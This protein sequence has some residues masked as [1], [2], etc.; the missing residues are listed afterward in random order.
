MEK[1]LENNER[2]LNSVIVAE[3]LLHQFI[4][5]PTKSYYAL[6]EEFVSGSKSHLTNKEKKDFCYRTIYCSQVALMREILCLVQNAVKRGRVNLTSDVFSSQIKKVKERTIIKGGKELSNF[7]Y[8][9]A[10]RNAFAHNNELSKDNVIEYFSNGIDKNKLILDCKDAGICVSLT[11]KD[12]QE[13]VEAIFK[14][15]NKTEALGVYPVR[16]ENAIKGGYFSTDNINRYITGYDG[17]NAVDLTLDDHQKQTINNFVSSGTI[18]NEQVLIPYFMDGKECGIRLV[19][20]PLIKQIFPHQSKPED[21]A[22]HKCFLFFLNNTIAE[23]LK[24]TKEECLKKA[25]TGVEQLDVFS[26]YCFNSNYYNFLSITNG[27]HSLLSDREIEDVEEELKVALGK[28]NTR[29]I[30]NALEHGTYYYNHNN[31]VEFYDGGKKLKHI[32]TINL[33]SAAYAMHK[34]VLERCKQNIEELS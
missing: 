28:E 30:R 8:I 9:K 17:K 3:K 24:R 23:D 2:S 34:T 13:I 32:A 29:H 27:L 15:I 10:I 25:Q 31:E 26:T 18:K 5:N 21:L 22:F 16:L 11:I 7:D 20:P 1:S 19:Y 6:A 12:M 14:S 4:M 33:S